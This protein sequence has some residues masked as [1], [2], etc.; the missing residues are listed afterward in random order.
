[1]K[2]YNSYCYNLQEQ[3]LSPA[4]VHNDYVR[5]MSH[6]TRPTVEKIHW[7]QVPNTIGIPA[8][9]IMFPCRRMYLLMVFQRV[10]V[11]IMLM[12]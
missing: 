4:W 6:L 10:T 11:V 7:Q 9:L 5:L 12:E 2:V 8:A 3:S 1:M